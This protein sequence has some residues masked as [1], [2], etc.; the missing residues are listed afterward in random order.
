MLSAARR[1]YTRR[2]FSRNYRKHSIEQ[3]ERRDLFAGLLD[4]SDLQY[5]G[6]F[7]LP[8][9]TFGA[10]SFDYGGTALAFNPANNSLFIVGHDW[11]QAVAEISIP[12]I[13]TGS[14][15]GLSTASVL[16]PFVD[17]LARVPNDTLEGNVKLGG[18]MVAGNQLI[19]SAYEFYDAE[20]DAVDSHFKLSSLN[21]S[22]AAVTGFFEVGNE[23]GG[24]VGGYMAAVP[25]EWQDEFGRLPFNGTGRGSHH[26]P[27]LSRPRGVRF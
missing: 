14:L 25:G 16:Q 2:P 22:N 12:T 9:G 10:S 19:V 5:L 20:G 15:S 24:Y 6:A 26:Q 27:H 8:S 21:L 18:L 3:L 23:G 7:R 13:R 17:V 4:Q 11:D 1:V